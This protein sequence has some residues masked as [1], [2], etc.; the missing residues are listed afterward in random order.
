MT[1]SNASDGATNPPTHVI[2]DLTMVTPSSQSSV[3]DLLSMSA[4]VSN[5]PSDHS[6]DDDDSSS[7]DESVLG[8]TFS[9]TSSFFVKG[10]Y[11]RKQSVAPVGY[12]ECDG[13]NGTS[14]SVDSWMHHRPSR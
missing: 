5:R 9:V 4:A 7:S 11:E 1:L 14:L 12:D 8:T 10:T 6:D 13:V 2:V 3:I